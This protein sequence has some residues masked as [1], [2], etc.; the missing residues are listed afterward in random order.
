LSFLVSFFLNRKWFEKKE[1]GSGMRELNSGFVFISLLHRLDIVH[2]LDLID[3][4]DYPL[5][6]DMLELLALISFIIWI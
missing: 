6:L 3:P 2:Y 1:K 5:L 4:H